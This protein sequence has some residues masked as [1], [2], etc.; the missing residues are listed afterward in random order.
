MP[1]DHLKPRESPLK[2]G[3]AAPDFEL[4]DQHRGTFKLSDALKQSDV[5]LSF[6]PMAFTGVCGTE[7]KC[8]TDDMAKWQAKGAQVIGISCDSNAA[9]KAWADQ[10]G[11][12]QTLL[13]DMHRAVC[14][15]YGLYW[16]DLNVAWRGTLVIGRDG[17]VKWSQKREI[18]DALSMDELLT[19]MG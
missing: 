7:M 9:L 19:A 8:V 1:N 12:K 6:F 4:P 15:A 17:K 16:S 11:L 18:K 10:M 13:A 5:V 14:K 3:E 2:I